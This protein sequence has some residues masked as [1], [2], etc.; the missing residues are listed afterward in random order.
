VTTDHCSVAILPVNDME[1]AQRFF[2]R[3]GFHVAKGYGDYRILAD[4]QG[5]QLH[6]TKA[7]EGWLK[8]GA[9]P[10]GLYLYTNEVDRL[11]T[12]FKSEIIGT[13]KAPEHKECGMYEFALNGPDDTLVRIGWPSA[14]VTK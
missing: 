8:P 2:E 7:V 5:W 11:A 1:A 9:N 6:L 4:G 14:M 12:E 3:L 13:N 10:F